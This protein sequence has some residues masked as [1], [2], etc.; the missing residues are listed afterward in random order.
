[1]SMSVPTMLIP[2]LVMAG[3]ALLLLAAGHDFVARTV[4]NWLACAVA[5][6]GIA[7]RAV[8]GG[9]TAGLAVG[10]VVFICAAIC[11]R[12]GLMGGGDVKLLAAT[13]IAGPPS[14]VLQFR[15]RCRALPAACSR[16]ATYRASPGAQPPRPSGRHSTAGSSAAR[17]TLAHPSGRSPSLRLRNRRRRLVRLAVGGCH[18]PTYRV[19]HADGFGFDRFR[20]RGVDFDT[21]DAGRDGRHAAADD[22]AGA[23]GRSR[24][25]CRRAAETGRPVVEANSD[26]RS[27]CAGR[28]FG[29]A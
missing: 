19:L 23:D 5:L 3:A 16:C 24:D 27:R 17:R 20:Y 1:M 12:R 18:G 2:G 11:W 6:L 4:P 25:P 8:A 14:L 9:L 29:H 21:P 28:Q 26:H 10:A 13:A 15:H 22:Q 7:L